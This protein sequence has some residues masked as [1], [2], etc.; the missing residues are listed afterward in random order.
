MIGSH[1]VRRLAPD[2]DV[3]AVTRKPLAVSSGTI[4]P[5]DSSGQ[6]QREVAHRQDGI[7][8][9]E[10]DLATPGFTEGLPSEIETVVHL[11]QSRQFRVF[12]DG[13]SD[14]FAVNVASSVELLDWARRIGARR[15][16][17]ASSGGIYGHGDT[18]F[19]EEDTI[20]PSRPLGFYLASK[21]ATELLVEDYGG[22]ITVVVLRFFFVYGAG[23]H[24]SMLLPR[25]ASAVAEGRPIVLQGEQGLRSNPVH[26]DDAVNALTGA[27][28][29]ERS[30]KINV[31]GPEVLD[32]RQIGEILGSY[33]GK[34]PVF[35]IVPGVAPLHLIG[36]IARMKSLLGP[37]SIA[38]KEGLA[39]LCAPL[40]A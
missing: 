10:R 1:L 40:L 37:P 31:A 26:V 29:L 3:V 33:L 39:E 19:K 27:I 36:D 7:I 11:A 22:L 9:V 2:R 25:L 21:H 13:A 38:P 14:V 18:G 12:P 28:G 4:P 30:V 34:D 8:W 16:I 6:I 24:P 15:F 23:Q 17:Y 32:L 5:D 20:G 35:E